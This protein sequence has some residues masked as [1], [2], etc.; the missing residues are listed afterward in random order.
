MK[1]TAQPVNEIIQTTQRICQLPAIPAHNWAYALADALT[2]LSHTLSVGVLIAHLDPQS[3]SISPISTASAHSKPTAPPLATTQPSP[4][5]THQSLYLQ[6][7]LE[8]LTS[9]GLELTP[10]ALTR[11][12]I[13]PLFI[14]HP[15]WPSTPIGRIF[16]TQHLQSPI[17]TI[18]PITKDHPGF[19]LMLTLAFEKDATSSDPASAQHIESVDHI[20]EMLEGLFPLIQRKANLALHRVTNPKAWLTDREHEILDQLILGSSVRVIAESL[21]RS[22]HTVHDH[23]KNLHKKLNASSRGELIATALGYRAPSDESSA[24]SPTID[25]KPI[26]LT[27]STRLTELKSQ[28]KSVHARP[29][30]TDAGAVAGTPEHRRPR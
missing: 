20:I 8:R 10:E 21:G 13:A 30:G 1:R 9:L 15:H 11:G 27:G 18:I 2:H 7:K 19:V 3:Q 28:Y 26:V 29:L 5:L 6:D 12:L 22:A 17:L 25:A 4:D 16:A 23:V 14:L 24:Q